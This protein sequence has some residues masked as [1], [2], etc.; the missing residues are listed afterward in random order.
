[1]LTFKNPSKS[2]SNNE[3]EHRVIGGLTFLDSTTGKV[4]KNCE[5][6][7]EESTKVFEQDDLDAMYVW[8]PVIKNWFKDNIVS[9]FRV[10]NG[11]Q[12]IEQLSQLVEQHYQVKLPGRN[13]ARCA[14]RRFEMWTPQ[15]ILVLNSDAQRLSKQM[16]YRRNFVKIARVED[17]RLTN[18]L[19][20]YMIDGKIHLDGRTE[21]YQY[22]IKPSFDN[23]VETTLE[24]EQLTEDA[25]VAF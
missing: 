16:Q 15:D 5:V 20:A 8:Q 7:F 18:M 25:F 2:K 24:D 9:E 3:F 19:S 14:E 23:A 11:H 6:H 22:I 12:I 17:G 1:M 4:Y 10:T 13:V 21:A